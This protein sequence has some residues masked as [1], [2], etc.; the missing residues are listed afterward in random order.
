MEGDRV[1]L[2]QQVLQVV[3]VP[4]KALSHNVNTVALRPYLPHLAQLSMIGPPPL[5]AHNGGVYVVSE[6]VS[7]DHGV[8]P[9]GDHNGG[10]YVGE[11]GGD[12]QSVA[13][14]AVRHWSV[15]MKTGLVFLLLSVCEFIIVLLF[16]VSIN[17][18]EHFI[19]DC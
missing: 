10:V 18:L 17:T 6:A 3:L 14:L 4:S 19:L 5:G 7:D 8:L 9:H 2:V 15:V 16:L 11:V 12:E 13:S 1:P